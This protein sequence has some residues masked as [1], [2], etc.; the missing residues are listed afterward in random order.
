MRPG[1]LW[2][3]L[4]SASEIPKVH[5]MIVANAFPNYVVPKQALKVCE[6][7]LVVAVNVSPLLSLLMTEPVCRQT[8]AS[9]KC[10]LRNICWP[11]FGRHLLP[12]T[13]KN[14]C[15]RDIEQV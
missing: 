7:L 5:S 12:A 10:N 1:V 3:N 2:A 14:S 15:L 11:P 8:L 9:A 13:R 4:I 6:A